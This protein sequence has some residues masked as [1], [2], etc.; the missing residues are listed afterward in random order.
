MA[1]FGGENLTKTKNEG[2]RVA[3]Y[4]VKRRLLIFPSPGIS[5]T[6]FYSVPGE[7]QDEENKWRKEKCR[8]RNKKY[9]KKKSVG[10]ELFV[11][12]RTDKKI[13]HI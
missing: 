5:L 12:E 1:S 11:G 6:F 9:L 2:G 8:R 3:K 13:P 7:E 4:T 10:S